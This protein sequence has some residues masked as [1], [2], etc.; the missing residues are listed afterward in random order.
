MEKL[1]KLSLNYSSADS[2]VVT[3]HKNR[4]V[5]TVLMK[6]H[7]ICFMEK[8]GKLPLNYPYYPFLS[9][10]IVFYNILTPHS[11]DSSQVPIQEQSDRDA[12]FTVMMKGKP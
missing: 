5:E 1:G 10:P 6:G 12:L 3:P 9:R 7:N 4:L 2:Y 11:D 8:F